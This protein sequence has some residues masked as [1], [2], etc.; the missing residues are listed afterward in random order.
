MWGV[1]QGPGLHTSGLAP[2]A[3]KIKDG[4]SRLRARPGK[5]KVQIRAARAAPG[6][7]DRLMG[8][9]RRGYIPAKYNSSTTLEEEVWPSQANELT[10]ELKR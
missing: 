7:P 3:G 2:A 9:T 5:N 10:F 1:A 4:R 8:A 6:K